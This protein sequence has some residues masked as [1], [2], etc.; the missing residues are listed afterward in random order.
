LSGPAELPSAEHEALIQFL[1][2]APVGLVQAGIDGEIV[3][4]NPIAAQHLIPLSRDGGLA[5]LFTALEGVAPE[6]RLLCASFDRPAGLVCDGRYVHLHH[7]SARAAPQILSLTLLKLDNERLA[8]VL[9]DVTLQVRRERQLRQSGEA[10]SDHLTGLANRRAFFEAAELE[11][12]RGRHLPRP[13]S[14]VM[15]D[16]D[17]FKSVNASFG[18]AAGDAVLRHLSIA[19]KS[20]FREVDVAA[21]IGGDE[22]AVLL[23][24]TDLAGAAAVAERL[25]MQV[26][27]Q[28]LLVDGARIAYTISLGV[29]AMDGSVAGL[30]ALQRRADRALYVAKARGRNQVVRWT[31]GLASG[32]HA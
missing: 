27:S 9:T 11:L 6:L 3:M 22:F 28:S 2:L 32:A 25:R 29:A 21:R 10:L 26:A 15:V 17:R 18:H 4:I 13:T 31:P 19:M 14:L 8:A 24:S 7:D 5:N 23:P 20:T 1:Y 30:D 16:A 12:C